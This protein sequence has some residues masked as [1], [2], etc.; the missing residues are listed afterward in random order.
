M[1]KSTAG[2]AGGSARGGRSPAA[3]SQAQIPGALGTMS[4]VRAAEKSIWY[5]PTEQ[6]IGFTA[7]GDRV[8][9]KAGT[10]KQVGFTEAEVAPLRNGGV[11]THNHPGGGSFS[12]ND[13]VMAS[14]LNLAEIRAVN[15]PNEVYSMRPPPGGWNEGY[16][17]YTLKPA[18]KY[19]QD[20]VTAEYK[21]KGLIGPFA[22][23]YAQL[24][25]N[26]E[27]WLRVSKQLGLDYRY[28]G[29]ATL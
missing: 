26:H 24:A 29:E 14:S 23:K 10:K 3:T 5:R 2:G 8:L 25:F 1:S 6:A 21:A 22:P 4:S 18:I 15:G 12:P 19:H 27:I 20:R 7:N 11:F 16:T 9:D 17:K 28:T 13:I